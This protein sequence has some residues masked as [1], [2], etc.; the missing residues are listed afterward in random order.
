MMGWPGPVTHRQYLAW[1]EWY[2]L[3]ANHPDR[4]DWYAMQIAAEVRRANAK[5]PKSVNVKD[6]KLTFGDNA[7]PK[8]SREQAAAFSKA[9]WFSILGLNHPVD[10]GYHTT[11]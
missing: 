2:K 8:M 5:N 1:I 9:A 11:E 6:M 4:S 7:G 3:E 10:I